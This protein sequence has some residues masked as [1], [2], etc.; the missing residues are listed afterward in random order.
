MIF[1]NAQTIVVGH[2]N[3]KVRI[4]VMGDG[5]IDRDKGLAASSVSSIRES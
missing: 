4:T 5:V 3:N 2:S 1:D